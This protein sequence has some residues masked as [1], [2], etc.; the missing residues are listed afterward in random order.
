MA[1]QF[2]S[3]NGSF[4]NDVSWQLVKS[5]YSSGS[6]TTSLQDFTTTSARINYWPWQDD[7]T[8]NLLSDWSYNKEKKQYSFYDMQVSNLDTITEIGNYTATLRW[9]LVDSP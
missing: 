3:E 4:A 1:K 8:G 6:L 7:G 5:D 9:T 2:T